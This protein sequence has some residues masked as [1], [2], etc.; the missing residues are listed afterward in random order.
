VI[1]FVALALAAPSEA[2]APTLDQRVAALESVVQSQDEEI[3]KLERRLDDTEKDAGFALKL[4]LRS[5]NA[6]CF[7]DTL[8]VSRRG[9]ALQR[10]TRDAQT[11][12]YVPVV[13]RRCVTQPRREGESYRWRGWRP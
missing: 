3:A 9:S 1:A 11:R 5:V 13:A 12:L 4:A 7:K 6:A 10:T 8:A 2:E